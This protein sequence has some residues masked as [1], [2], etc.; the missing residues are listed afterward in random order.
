MTIEYSDFAKLKWHVQGVIVVL[1]AGSLLGLLW[2]QFLSPMEIEIA[3]KETRLTQIRAEVARAVQRQQQLAEV[4]A[5][6]EELQQ[7][8]NDLK[9]ILPLQRETAEIITEIE[10][11]AEASSVNV[12]RIAPRAPVD[13][14]VYSAWAWDYQFQSTFHNMGRFLDSVRQLPR[15]VTITGVNLNSTG[16]GVTTSVGG[17]YTATTFV[18]NEEAPLTTTETTNR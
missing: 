10:S 3:E 9:A 5:E 13:Q 4:R 1:V 18:Y 2:Y 17:T 11:L 6:S 15:I 16:D 7:Q 14:E 8:L 12:S